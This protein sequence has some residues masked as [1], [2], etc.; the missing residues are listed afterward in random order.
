MGRSV[1]IDSTS[2]D[3]KYVILPIS[4]FQFSSLAK[5][6]LPAWPGTRRGEAPSTKFPG[7]TKYRES[8][9]A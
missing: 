1:T 8:P 7:I 6:K 5:A 3:T 2:I 4:S 9:V